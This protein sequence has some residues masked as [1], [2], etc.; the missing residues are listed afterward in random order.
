MGR[1]GAAELELARGVAEDTELMVPDSSEEVDDGETVGLTE[2][3]SEELDKLEDVE[4]E[5]VE[6]TAELVVLET[7]DDELVELIAL[8]D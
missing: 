7:E 3:G 1:T 8:G 5:L 6:A 4:D 2:D